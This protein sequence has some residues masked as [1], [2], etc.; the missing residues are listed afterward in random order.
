MG[1]QTGD[2]FYINIKEFP[3]NVEQTK[4]PRALSSEPL[5]IIPGMFNLSCNYSVWA[6]EAAAK[7]QGKK[8]IE[9]RF[10]GVRVTKDELDAIPLYKLMYLKIKEQYPDCVD[11][12]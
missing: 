6:S 12:L 9:Q 1:V 2:G 4:Y 3:I 10:A 8:R 7:K 11:I 5:T